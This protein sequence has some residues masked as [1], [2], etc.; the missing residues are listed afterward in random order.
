MQRDAANGGPETPR[1]RPF[2]AGPWVVCHSFVLL[3]CATSRRPTG[4]GGRRGGDGSEENR[5][6]VH[7]STINDPASRRQWQ[8]VDRQSRMRQLESRKV[9]ISA[10]MYARSE[11]EKP[12]SATSVRHF[13][14]RV[15]CLDY[16]HPLRQCV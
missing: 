6:E 10:T 15:P 2:P 1:P 3:A 9:A 11:V 8:I 5:V 14:H 13:N 4:E 7:G 16:S 12:V